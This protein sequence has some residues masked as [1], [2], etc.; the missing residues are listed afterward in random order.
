MNYSAALLWYIL[1]N[2]ANVGA[3]GTYNKRWVSIH[4]GH[5]AFVFIKMSEKPIQPSNVRNEDH[6]RD[7]DKLTKRQHC[8]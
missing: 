6:C 3:K 1:K 7:N 8:T 5:T 2:H 4:V